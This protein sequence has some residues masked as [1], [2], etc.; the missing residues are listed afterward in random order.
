MSLLNTNTPGVSCNIDFGKNFSI[1]DNKKRPGLWVSN[2]AKN[3]GLTNIHG[4]VK[5]NN[6]NKLETDLGNKL[7]NVSLKVN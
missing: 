5:V 6:S 4:V 1:T 3:E 2:P 7:T